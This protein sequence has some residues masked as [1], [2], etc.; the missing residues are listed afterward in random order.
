MSAG[1]GGS[2]PPPPTATATATAPATTSPTVTPTPAGPTATPTPTGGGGSGRNLLQNGDFEAGQTGWNCKNCA[3]SVVSPGY[4]GSG[5]AGQVVVSG[6]S[7]WELR[8]YNLALEPNTAY[9]LRFEGKADGSRNLSV[10]LL[11]HGSPYTNYGLSES[12]SL[13]TGWQTTSYEFTTSG[14]SSPVNDARLRLRIYATGVYHFDNV[15]LEKVDGSAATATAP[16]MPTTTATPPAGPTAT[17]TATATNPPG[18]SGPVHRYSLDEGSGGYGQ[19]QRR[20]RRRRPPRTHLGQRAT[21]RRIALPINFSDPSGHRECASGDWCAAGL[22]NH[23]ISHLHNYQ[24]S[25]SYG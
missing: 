15:V 5:H 19:R 24:W 17:P 11:K 23:T 3:W 22:Q 12:V 4:G 20:Q 16:A 8:Q 9:R 14:F 1:C 7:S 25:L 10:Q 13:N 2:T 21:K 18:G 6:G